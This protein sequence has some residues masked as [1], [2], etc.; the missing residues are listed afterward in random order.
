VIFWLAY[1]SAELH[2]LEAGLRAQAQVVREGLRE[3]GSQITYEGRPRLPGESAQG[4]AMGAVLLAAQGRVLSQSAQAPSVAGVEAVLEQVRA[5][6]V[7]LLTARLDGQ[8]QRVLVEPLVLDDGRAAT[9][10]LARP[11]V[12]YEDRL[13]Q[14]GT[15]LAATVITLA[16]LA[17]VS[18]HLLAGRVL[19]PVRV[20]T[21]MARELSEHDLHR[22]ITLALPPDELGEL[23]ATFND[24]LERLE[25]AFGSLNRF[26]ADAAHELRT[27][28]TLMRSEIQVTLRG[29][30][31]LAE[32]RATLEAVLSDVERLTRTADQLLL[33][34]RADAGVLAPRRER[35]DVDDIVDEAAVRWQPTLQQRGV[36]LCVR[37][38]GSGAMSADHD[39]VRRLLDNLIDNA[40]RHT[41]PGGTITLG[42][43]TVDHGVELTVRDT[44]PGV[45]PAIRS[46][47]F[48]RFTRSDSARGR[49]TGGAGLGLSI[50]DAI[51]RLHGGRIR[52]DEDVD[53]GACFRVW[54]PMH[55]PEPPS[56]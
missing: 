48:E 20:I 17:A 4:L 8:D 39:M 55:P 23:A 10:V 31:D 7:T 35:V 3:Q 19:T 37:L 1:S 44:G 13:R 9:L 45:A 25:A 36:R 28:L 54:L 33:L 12:V 11:L 40:A 26:T 51:T 34:A 47:I 50:C 41:G 14:A 27:P 29:A 43:A 42:G 46:R 15:Y 16:A 18:A 32:H 38:A 24:M 22:R 30:G 2:A 5:G 56:I 53:A 49:E 21:A 52:L 6:G